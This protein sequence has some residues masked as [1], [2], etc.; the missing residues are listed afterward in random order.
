MPFGKTDRWRC[1]NSNVRQLGR[2]KLHESLCVPRGRKAKRA[3]PAPKFSRFPNRSF[4]KFLNFNLN[5][6][7]VSTHKTAGD[8]GYGSQNGKRSAWAWERSRQSASLK[9]KPRFQLLCASA[10]KQHAAKDCDDRGTYQ[11][12]WRNFRSAPFSVGRSGSFCAR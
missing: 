4:V 10:A 2:Q 11:V 12:D 5:D 6:Q 9:A 8:F 3:Y 1:L 7:D